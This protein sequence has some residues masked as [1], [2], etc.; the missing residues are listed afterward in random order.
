MRLVPRF[1]CVL[2][3]ARRAGQSVR[4]KDVPTKDAD[5]AE[6]VRVRMLIVQSLRGG[7]N[8]GR[9]V[10]RRFTGIMREWPSGARQ[11][12]QGFVG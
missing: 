1:Q 4:W 9:A 3:T 8:P 12:E 11:S 7:A 10:V 2:A 5:H 6:A